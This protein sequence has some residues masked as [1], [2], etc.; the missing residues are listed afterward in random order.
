MMSKVAG[1]NMTSKFAQKW[2]ILIS[3]GIITKD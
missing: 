1:I 2:M 3:S